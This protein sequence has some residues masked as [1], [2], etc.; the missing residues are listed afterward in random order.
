MGSHISTLRES[1]PVMARLLT[2]LAAL[3]AHPLTGTDVPHVS[4]SDFHDGNYQLLPRHE[5]SLSDEAA[6]DKG[7]QAVPQE[8][9]RLCRSGEDS[10]FN[11]HSENLDKSANISLAQYKGNVSLVVNLASF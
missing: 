3:G 8:N 5:K 6:E 1:S 2:L 9:F 10:L 7:F 11:Y 4:E